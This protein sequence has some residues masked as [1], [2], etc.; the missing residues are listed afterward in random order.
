MRHD[1]TPQQTTYSAIFAKFAQ[2]ASTG[3]RGIY[4]N[5]ANFALRCIFSVSSLASRQKSASVSSYPGASAGRDAGQSVWS[6]PCFRFA[7]T[8]CSARLQGITAPNETDC[9]ALRATANAR[10]FAQ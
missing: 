8:S 6:K 4:A 7:Q 9:N 1:L 5:F 2:K 3:P 10:G